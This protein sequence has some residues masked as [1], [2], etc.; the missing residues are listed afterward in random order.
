MIRLQDISKRYNV[1][2]K[3]FYA[4]R[5]VNLHVQRG[6]SVAIRGRSGAG[7]STLLHILGCLDTYSTGAYFLEGQDL[8]DRSSSEAAKLRN[9]HFGFVLQDFSLINHQSALYNVMSPMLF[10]KTPFRV[11]KERAMAALVAMGVAEQAKKD[12]LAMSGGQRQRVALAR[13]IVCDPPILLA[14]EPTGSLDS[15]TETEIMELLSGLH[16]QGKTLLI[17]THDD[18]VA[19]YCDRTVLLSDGKIIE[20]SAAGKAAPAEAD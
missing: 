20:P 8:S 19:A 3:P 9:S 12:V 5:D 10:N 11:M 18:S 14:D 17:V 15:E 16:R 4:L 2:G 6:E 13:A 7:K 1:G